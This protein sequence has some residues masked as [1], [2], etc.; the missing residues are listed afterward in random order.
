MAS[1]KRIKEN[2]NSYY[3]KQLENP[4]GVV[5]FDL[6]GTLAKWYS[7]RRGLNETQMYDPSYHYFLNLEPIYNTI[8][9][10]EEL[11]NM[12][13]PIKILTASDMSVIS[14]KVEWVKKYL[15]FLTDDD[16]EITPLDKSKNDYCE[17]RPENSILIDD[18][19]PN[20]VSFN[21]TGIKCITYENGKHP[22]EYKQFE[23]YIS[24]FSDLTNIEKYIKKIFLEK[25]PDM[26]SKVTDIPTTKTKSKYY[27]QYKKFNRFHPSKFFTMCNDKTFIC[28]CCASG[29]HGKSTGV[30]QIP[31]KKES[32]YPKYHCFACGETGTLIDFYSKKI[33]LKPYEIIRDLFDTYE[34]K[35]DEKDD[36]IIISKPKVIVDYTE[37]FE[38][39][40]KNNNYIYLES[41][42]ITKETQDH[43]NIGYDPSWGATEKIKKYYPTARCI[44]PLGNN[45]YLARAISNKVES[46]YQKQKAGYSDFFNKEELYEAFNKDKNIKVY[47]VEG[48]IDA[49]SIWQCVREKN[50]NTDTL[51]IPV[52]LG[53]TS[54]TLRFL[55]EM[56]VKADDKISRL[57]IVFALDNDKAGREAKERGK[58][59]LINKGVKED[60]IKSLYLEYYND[61]NECLEEDEE[62]L[63]EALDLIE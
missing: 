15:P 11:H 51:H 49:M 55:D 38:E 26:I 40:R 27:E 25:N 60:K 22:E 3:E 39:C 34:N 59:F 23:T 19:T 43:F 57:D 53:S 7:D 63:L 35:E 16:I 13:I 46:K 44:I 62:T 31:M 37:Y 17:H 58:E 20:L 8:K 33:G 32:A 50:E 9:L 42:G 12:N 61:I 2:V 1:Y 41:R 54:N 4:N 18:Y 21:G 48:E 45:G 30:G 24:F 29:S 6:D 36:F 5:Y 56:L 28:P 10:A 14:D 47:I 52:S